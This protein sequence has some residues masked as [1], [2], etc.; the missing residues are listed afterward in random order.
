MTNVLNGQAAETEDA[1]R[2]RAEV[3]NADA[4]YN[5]GVLLEGRGQGSE[6]AK[7][8]WRAARTGDVDAMFNLA[9]V[10]EDL[11]KAAEATE[12]YSRAAEAGDVDARANLEMLR[13]RA[14]HPSAWTPD[15]QAISN[16]ETY[17]ATSPDPNVRPI[18]K[19][20]P[21]PATTNLGHSPPP[22]PPPHSH[23]AGGQWEQ[24]A[25]VPSQAKRPGRI[26]RRVL[27]GWNVLA[28]IWLIA[29]IVNA[30]VQSHTATANCSADFQQTC[31]SA[32]NVG[33]LIGVAIVVFFW[34]AGDVIL[35]VLYLV[36]GR[37]DRR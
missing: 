6:A 35:G 10:L 33:A 1:Y 37:S 26:L 12:W 32:Y 13:G 25:N 8:Y 21:Y 15:Q 16:P 17:S 19:E 34:V 36:R 28:V 31:Q 14:C 11:G 27:I 24:P 29:G 23:A 9:G 2:Q 30:A 4:M 18:F 22:P 20:Q 5:L 3:G 7:W